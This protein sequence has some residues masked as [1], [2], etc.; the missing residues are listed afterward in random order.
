MPPKKVKNTEESKIKYKKKPIKKALRMELWKNTFGDT[1]KGNCYCCNRELQID[2]FE[3]GHIIPEVEGGETHINNLKVV[4]KS[5]NTSCATQNMEEFKKSLKTSEQ[6]ESK[7]NSEM[8]KLKDELN[9]MKLENDERK[10]KEEIQKENDKK[11]NL[12]KENSVPADSN[13]L[14]SVMFGIPWKNDFDMFCKTISMDKKIYD[15]WFDLFSKSNKKK[16]ILDV[17]KKM[18]GEN[19]PD[20]YP[21]FSYYKD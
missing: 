17:Q 13:I 19:R 12:I 14:G 2:N 9:K 11:Y 20:K 7:N 16:I 8:E 5:C 15:Q 21:S 4:C 10:L 6:K 3:A 1:L 18:L